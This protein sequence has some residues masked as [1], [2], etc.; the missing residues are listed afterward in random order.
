MTFQD[1]WN[2][3]VNFQFYTTLWISRSVMTYSNFM[4]EGEWYRCSKHRFAHILGYG[5]SDLE[6][7]SIHSY[8]TSSHDEVWDL[9]LPNTCYAEYWTTTKL[10]PY[11]K[12]IYLMVRTTIMPKGGNE[13]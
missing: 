9:H 8:A 13:T 6:K 7:E 11:F 4:V 3:E 10:A 12:Y 5:D 1:D 2:N